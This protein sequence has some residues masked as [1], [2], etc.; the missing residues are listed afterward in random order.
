MRP[1]NAL[2]VEH[3]TVHL[4]LELLERVAAR[5]AVGAIQADTD[6]D[7]LLDLFRD[8]VDLCH[9]GKEELALFP[10]MLETGNPHA[11][12]HVDVMLEEHVTGREHVQSLRAAAEAFRQGHPEAG[13]R[14]QNAARAYRLM[15]AG[16]I[17]KEHQVV[18]PSAERHLSE[19]RKLDLLE[20]FQLIEQEMF[21]GNRL[22]DCH[23]LLQDLG[24]RYPD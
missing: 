20:R 17:E 1:T 10:A 18:F 23:S 24:L 14:A 8:F 11:E 19:A 12:R 7:R 4:A 21:G 9:H 2:V 22:Q 16:H 15:L 6:L 5:M 13:T 3:E